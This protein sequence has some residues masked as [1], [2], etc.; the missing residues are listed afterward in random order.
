MVKV[1]ARFPA[2]ASGG[3]RNVMLVMVLGSR[4]ASLG[5]TDDVKE[6]SPFGD[7]GDDD[8]EEDDGLGNGPQDGD[9]PLNDGDDDDPP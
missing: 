6:G 1:V 2:S 7:G 8:A 9:A 5:D 3:M 4:L